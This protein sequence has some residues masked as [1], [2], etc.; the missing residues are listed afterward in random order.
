MSLSNFNPKFPAQPD[1]TTGQIDNT[2][3]D[4]QWGYITTFVTSITTYLNN[5]VIALLNKGYT[6]T[7]VT[8]KLT[9]GGTNGSMT[10]V[11]GVLTE[12]TPA[13]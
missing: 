13:T 12:Q 11:N 4:R 3:F 7:I 10:F 9:G 1:R 5:T 2:Y 8:A 6:G